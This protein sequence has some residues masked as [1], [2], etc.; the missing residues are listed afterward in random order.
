M[1]TVENILTT[2][3]VARIHS[4]FNNTIVTISNKDGKIISRSSS[5]TLGF[6]GPRKNTPFAAS[7][8]AIKVANEA[9]EYGLKTV[10]VLFKGPVAFIESAIKALQ[11]AGLEIT[12][13]K[14]STQIPH[15]SCKPPKMRI[16]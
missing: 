15:N 8:T 4:H 14:C 16:I 2:S 1:P 6:I 3:G 5:D 13:L 12:L 9:K 10:E 11:T 7:E